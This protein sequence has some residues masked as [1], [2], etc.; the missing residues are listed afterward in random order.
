MVNGHTFDYTRNPLGV[1]SRVYPHISMAALGFYLS[2]ENLLKPKY[3]TISWE[4]F[5]ICVVEITG[6]C[7]HESQYSV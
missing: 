2:P 5:Q 3:P 6:I 1:T 7:I 4:N